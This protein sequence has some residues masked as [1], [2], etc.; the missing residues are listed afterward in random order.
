MPTVLVY[1][2]YVLRV[3]YGV[4]IA[5]ISLINI[6]KAIN[7]LRALFGAMAAA[8]VVVIMYKRGRKGSTSLEISLIIIT[9]YNNYIIK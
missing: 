4:G 5:L 6:I 7:S 9:L 8:I 2:V 3:I 1:K